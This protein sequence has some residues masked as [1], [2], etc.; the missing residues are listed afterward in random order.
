MNKPGLLILG[1]VLG[2]VVGILSGYAIFKE[3]KPG[4]SIPAGEQY[5][6]RLNDTTAVRHTISV[7]DSG[8][9]HKLDTIAVLNRGW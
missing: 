2:F 3:G 6:Y 7:S 1:I 8:V 9:V 5:N 4:P